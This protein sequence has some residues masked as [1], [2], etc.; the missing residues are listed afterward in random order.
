MAA[1]PAPVPGGTPADRY[2]ARI[3]PVTE[4]AAGKV[5]PSDFVRRG[6]NHQRMLPDE[7]I[8]NWT[9]EWSR[10]LRLPA[11]APNPS[12]LPRPIKRESRLGAVRITPDREPYA[13]SA[14]QA[15]AVLHVADGLK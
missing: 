8:A 5:F 14:E 6:G 2:D 9:A 4:V 12:R 10:S 13:C 3:L 1:L 15:L 11:R 7:R